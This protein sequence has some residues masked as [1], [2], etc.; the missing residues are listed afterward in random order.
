MTIP[1]RRSGGAIEPSGRLWPNGEFTVGYAPCGGMEREATLDEFLDAATAHFDLSLPSNSHKVEDHGK[2]RRGTKG[3]TADGKRTVRCA[4]ECMQSKYG[5]A[6]LS[7]VTLTLPSVTYEESWLLSTC[8]SEIVRV[9][10]QRIKRALEKVGLPTSYVSVTEMQPKRS[11]RE[12]HPAL[13]L[14][15]VIVGRHRS[16]GPWAFTPKF[17]AQNWRAVISTYVPGVENWDSVE[18]VQRVKKDCSGYLSKYISK[19]MSMG[20]PPR[21]DGTGWSLPTAWYNLSINLRRWVKIHTRTD[22]R[23]MESIEIACRDGSASK[24]C[25][26]VHAGTFEF[27]AGP[28]PHYFVGKLNKEGMR[29]FLDIW[30]AYVGIPS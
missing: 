1:F 5:K 12:G 11:I 25:H 7:F 24:L 18:N 20:D 21:S 28:G 2:P 13:H 29:V 9:F 10:F 26:Y 23:L 14:H 30:R 4:A 16:S 15:F 8:W 3:L 22:S 17:F 19:G 6:R 27:G